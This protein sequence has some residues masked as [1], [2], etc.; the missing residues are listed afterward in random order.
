MPG[1]VEI[2]DAEAGFRVF[3]ET[4]KFRLQKKCHVLFQST[5]II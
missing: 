1:I 4:D 2:R 3:L 5:L